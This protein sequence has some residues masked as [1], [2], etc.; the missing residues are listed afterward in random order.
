MISNPKSRLRSG[1][2]FWAWTVWIP[3]GPMRLSRLCTL[4][5]PIFFAECV[6]MLNDNKIMNAF[7]VYIN[8]NTYVNLSVPLICDSYSLYL[9]GNHS[10]LRLTLYG[11][12]S[13]NSLLVPKRARKRGTSLL[14]SNF[15]CICCCHQ[16]WVSWQTSPPLLNMLT[17][18]ILRSKGK[19]S[20][21]CISKP[22]VDGRNPAPPG[23]YKTLGCLKFSF[24]VYYKYYSTGAQN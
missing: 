1:N 6:L 24:C 7:F 9:Y 15:Y 12:C 14:S 18:V 8:K 11:K 5:C 21:C 23:M 2:P 20:K 16:V 19:C 17:E 10:I 13:S 4:N 3:L 22:T